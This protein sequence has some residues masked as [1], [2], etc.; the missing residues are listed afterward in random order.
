MAKRS[1]SLQQQGSATPGPTPK[2]PRRRAKDHSKQ[3][4]ARMPLYELSDESF[5]LPGK[6]RRSCNNA[7]GSFPHSYLKPDAIDVQHENEEVSTSGS[8]WVT[9]RMIADVR[10]ALGEPIDLPEERNY[11]GLYSTATIEDDQATVIRGE[12][13]LDL[14]YEDGEETISGTEDSSVKAEYTRGL[15]GLCKTVCEEVL[16]HGVTTEECRHMCGR[17][18]M[19]LDGDSL[20]EDGFKRCPVCDVQFKGEAAYCGECTVADRDWTTVLTFIGL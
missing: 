1:S 20:R 5:I 13:F 10:K 12:G 11:S 19:T 6:K 15:P 9:A 14:G 18:G 7:D 17:P 8:E 2:K 16:G 4:L 3:P